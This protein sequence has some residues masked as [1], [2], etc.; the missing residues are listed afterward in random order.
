MTVHKLMR[1]HGDEDWEAWGDDWHDHA[2]IIG[3]LDH[4]SGWGGPRKSLEDHSHLQLDWG[5]RMWELSLD[6]VRRL[7]ASRPRSER[8]EWDRPFREAAERQ[9]ALLDSLDASARYAVV[10]MEVY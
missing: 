9:E 10:W 3:E 4:V 2:D 1:L 8:D 5:A 7:T 6:E